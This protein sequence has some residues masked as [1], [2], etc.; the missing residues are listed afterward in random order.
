MPDILSSGCMQTGEP[1]VTAAKTPR[2]ASRE[3]LKSA[4]KKVI[5][6][7]SCFSAVTRS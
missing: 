6:N 4:F 3:C 7:V 2:K 1:G 5:N